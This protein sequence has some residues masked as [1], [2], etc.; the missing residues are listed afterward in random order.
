MKILVTGSNG[1]IGTELVKQLATFYPEAEI[2][3][4]NRTKI[5]N[6]NKS[7]SIDLLIAS[8][9]ELANMLNIIKP[10]LIFHAAW[11][12]NHSD[13]LTSEINI[14]WEK[15]T[16]K[17]IDAFYNS[18]G[19]K[20]IGLGS[21]IEYDWNKQAPFKENSINL[22]GNNFLYGKSK[23]NV[24]LHLSKLKDISYQWGRVFF[25]FGPGQSKNRLI[26]LIINS[27][28][29]GVGK[30][31]VNRNLKRDYIS[32][33][34]IAKQVLMMS[35][36]NYSG[37]LNICSSNPIGIDE[38]INMIENIIKEKALISD[39]TYVDKFEINE[40]SGCNDILKKYFPSYEYN[41]D[42]MTLH[43]AK[44]IE[45]YKITNN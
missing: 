23:L 3:E 8:S 1:I 32:T 15:A 21:S 9:Q 4:L 14:L 27:A 2:Y 45:H 5:L 31:K 16:I 44:T 18:G 39:D 19:F 13:Y 22:N 35:K 41:K 12:T 42:E 29:N 26:P 37:S 17:L 40:I 11:Y 10:K 38:L 28:I 7:L 6:N 43:M 24:Y 33:I 20:F 34:E 25:V 36:C 30:I